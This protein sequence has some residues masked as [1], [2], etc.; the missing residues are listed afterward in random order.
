MG[1]L[2]RIKTLVDLA[3][4]VQIKPSSSDRVNCQMPAAPALESARF[5]NDDSTS[6]NSARS[7]GNPSLFEDLLECFNVA[8]GTNDSLAE[9]FFDPELR[10]NVV[11]QF[12][13]RAAS[14]RGTPLATI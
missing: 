13:Q 7:G 12:C 10:V 1:R 6:G 4:D 14:V 3:I 8:A 5:S 2:E 9:S 11:R